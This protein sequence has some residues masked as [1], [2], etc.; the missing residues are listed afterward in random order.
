MR[1]PKVRARKA[2]AVGTRRGLRTSA[3]PKETCSAPTSPTAGRVPSAKGLWFRSYLTNRCFGP[4]RHL[5]D[6]GVMRD[7]RVLL[8]SF[9]GRR[10]GV[11]KSAVS[12]LSARRR[13]EHTSLRLSTVVRVTYGPR[14]F[15]HSHRR[16][17]PTAFPSGS[18]LKC[19]WRSERVE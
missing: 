15:N 17:N 7:P 6:R 19:G 12:F 16:N 8:G 3:P 9:A 4:T 14:P 10:V 18:S 2:S 5:R 1:R 11:M 13:Y